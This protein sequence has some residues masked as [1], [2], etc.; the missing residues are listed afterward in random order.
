M[1]RI[2]NVYQT[3]LALANKEQRGYITPQEFNLLANKAQ[4]DIFE[5]YFSD[6]RV[7][8]REPSIDVEYGERIRLIQDKINIFK[9]YKSRSLVTGLSGNTWEFM[10]PSD[11][12]SLGSVFYTPNTTSTSTSHGTLD[13]LVDEADMD[14][15]HQMMLSPLVKP[16]KKRPV[17]VRTTHT[18]VENSP[19]YKEV[20]RMYPP[21]DWS[22]D[23][24]YPYF[25]DDTVAINYIVRPSKVKWGYVVVNSKALY[26]ANASTDFEL[27]ESDESSLVNKILELAG[28]AIQKPDLSELV[29]RNEQVKE[30]VKNK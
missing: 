19:A 2:D 25:S 13:I 20:I 4:M 22:K 30:A 16:T 7:A 3:V 17:Y 24:N 9:V 28:I 12:Y 15:I 10:L 29:L 18:N 21:N 26:N 8:K 1:I 5:S 23:V 6:L 27:H 14:T 11:V